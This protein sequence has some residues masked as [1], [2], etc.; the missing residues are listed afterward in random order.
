MWHVAMLNCTLASALKP[1]FCKNT[2]MLYNLI[3]TSS[4]QSE[5]IMN[6]IA[7]AEHLLVLLAHFIQQTETVS[8]GHICRRKPLPLIQIED[9]GI[10][11]QLFMKS[12]K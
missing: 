2:E 11:I 1:I 8:M 3:L 5:T 9:C 7:L 12:Q 6:D 4:L 10:R